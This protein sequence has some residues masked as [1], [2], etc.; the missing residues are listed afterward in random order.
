MYLIKSIFRYFK[1]DD[2]IFQTLNI[3]HFNL[4]IFQTFY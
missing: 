4:E 1:Y 3:N 2:Y